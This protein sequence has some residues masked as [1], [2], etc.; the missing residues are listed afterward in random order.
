MAPEVLK[1]TCCVVGGGPA[2]IVLGYLLAR[3]GVKAT[4]LE[5]HQ[6]F[7][8]DFRGDTVHPSTLEILNELG[9]LK[10]FL[11]LP[12]QEV[13]SLAVIVGD[14][15]LKLA[16]FS[17]VPARCKFV[18]LMP[19]WDFLNF[20]SRHAQSFPSFQLLMEHEA[21]G[22]MREGDR[23]VGVEA[24]SKGREIQVLADLVVGC[25]GRHSVARAA[26]GLEL[27]EHG[28]PI[29]VLWFRISR[30]PED[31]AQVLGSVNYGKALILINR[32]DYFQA[33]LIVE[34]GSFEEIKARGLDAFR[35]DIRQIAPF[36][37]ERS[38]EL[39]DWQQISV[40]TVQINRLRRWYRPGLLCIG[41]A[42]HAMSPA[43]G[44]G[45]N[46]AIQDAVAAA[47]LLVRP[48]LQRNVTEVALAAVQRRRTL[49]TRVTQAIQ[50]AA[51]R[52]LARVFKNPG[53]IR[54]PWQLKAAAQIPGIQRAVGY[55][56]GIG[57]RPERVRDQPA[58]RPERKRAGSAVLTALGIAAAAAGI[59]WAL[60]KAWRR[61]A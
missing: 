46:L 53:P 56:V 59:G 20:L 41:D 24:R 57:A 18:A 26:A 19:Q 33:G 45:I 31:P 10:E 21:T 42:A 35:A 60:W 6:D 36:L 17:H 22:L 43:G 16:D 9:L 25:D 52:G 37:G 58:V 1:T 34:K 44:V 48:L 54:A 23:I 38:N 29:D 30:G 13:A 7:F 12:H 47:N 5:K 49:P 11:E 4:V 50:L 51:H 32:S 14:S 3:S 2:G 8:R 15:K 40:L 61:A 27:I 28:A 39:R 55:A